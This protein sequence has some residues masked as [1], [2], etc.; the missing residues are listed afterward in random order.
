VSAQPLRLSE[1]DV[2]SFLACSSQKSRF[3]RLSFVPMECL[4]G[5][6]AQCRSGWSWSSEVREWRGKVVSIIIGGEEVR[7]GVVVVM[8]GSK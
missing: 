5:V 4:N 3:D 2:G 8:R 6:V 7:S 1:L